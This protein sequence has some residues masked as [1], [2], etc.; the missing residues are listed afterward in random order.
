MSTTTPVYQYG[1][2]P[3]IRSKTVTRVKEGTLVTTLGGGE[4]IAYVVKDAAG[5][6][7]DSGSSASEVTH[8]SDGIWAA[9]LDVLPVGRYTI[10]WTLT[11]GGGVAV[12]DDALVIRA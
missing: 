10:R 11:I 9:K 12:E 4:S 3:W 5:A 7:V 6:T 2:T 8:W 1:E